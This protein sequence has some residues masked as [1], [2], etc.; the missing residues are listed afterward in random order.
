[1][2]G[3]DGTRRQHHL[4]NGVVARI[5]DVQRI[6]PVVGETARSVEARR[7]AGRVRRP[8][9]AGGTRDGGDRTGGGDQ[10]AHGAVARVADVHVASRV[11][12]ETLYEVEA[13]SCAGAVGA[14][15]HAR[16]SRDR[17][18]RAGGEDDLADGEVVDV[19][20]IEIARSVDGKGH[21]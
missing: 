20:E 7:G 13:R 16:K 6:G 4:A 19:G 10:L 3:G 9:D 8:V 15:R 12:D 18:H 5:G 1:G 11:G 21:R 17:C 2:D 14:A